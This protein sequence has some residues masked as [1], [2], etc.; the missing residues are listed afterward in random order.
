[1]E[2]KLLIANIAPT[3]GDLSTPSRTPGMDAI[4]RTLPI[5]ACDEAVPS[6]LHTSMRD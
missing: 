6:R 3:L 1:M 2:R 5:E 4:F